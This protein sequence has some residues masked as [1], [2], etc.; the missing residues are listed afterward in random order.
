MVPSHGGC[1]GAHGPTTAP[2]GRRTIGTKWLHN[3]TSAGVD[4]RK[5]AA[6][7]CVRH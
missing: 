3:P 6:C 2:P 5:V 4:K 1:A 7:G